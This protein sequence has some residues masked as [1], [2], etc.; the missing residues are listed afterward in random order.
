MPAVRK[1]FQ[2]IP[3]ELRIIVPLF[4][5][6]FFTSFLFPFPSATIVA[7]GASA[8]V[9][10]IVALAVVVYISRRSKTDVHDANGI[11]VPN[12][13]EHRLASIARELGKAYV[14]PTDGEPQSKLVKVDTVD[15]V[16]TDVLIG[17]Q[18]AVTGGR[19]S[20]ANTDD[21]EVCITNINSTNILCYCTAATLQPPHMQTVSTCI[22]AS[23]MSR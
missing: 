10:A 22:I 6:L 12:K 15:T 17:G 21:K 8:A 5:I 3:M 14:G 13:L 16:N 11:F 20:R 18:D 4:I 19:L 1:T 23:P 7:A 9:G 2:K